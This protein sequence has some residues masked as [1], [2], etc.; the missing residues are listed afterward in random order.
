M[1]VKTVDLD[2]RIYRYVEN[3]VFL[4]GRKKTLRKYYA[5]GAKRVGKTT[6][7]SDNQYQ[8]FLNYCRTGKHPDRVRNN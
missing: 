4:D 6:R 5:S 2:G 3:G 8:L 7:S 1:K